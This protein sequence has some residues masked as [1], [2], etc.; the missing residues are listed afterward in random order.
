MEEEKKGSLFPM[1]L[2]A[3][4]LTH[5]NED[6]AQPKRAGDLSLP[7]LLKTDTQLCSPL[8]LRLALYTEVFVHHKGRLV[9]ENIGGVLLVFQ[10]FIYKAPKDSTTF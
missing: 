2:R 1:C 4:K 8:W 6:P 10:A 7:N 3:T 5:H 9:S